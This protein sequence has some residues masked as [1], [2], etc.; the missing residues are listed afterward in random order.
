M[1]QATAAAEEVELV[2]Y[3]GIASRQSHAVLVDYGRDKDA[4]RDA[5]A[6]A[7]GALPEH[8]SQFSMGYGRLFALFLSASDGIVFFCLAY[9]PLTKDQ[10][11]SL[12]G[13]VRTAFLYS[14]RKLDLHSGTKLPDAARDNI[15][16][17]FAQAF[18]SHRGAVG[19]GGVAPL[20][21]Y[22]DAPFAYRTKSEDS[23]PAGL[24]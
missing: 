5:V 19:P 12:L 16:K 10:A 18:R 6:A 9:D 1:S 3:A 4:F 13:R 2:A 15:R 24:S 14:A 8:V 23:F 22:H 20:T 21:I 7:L 11:R 17:S